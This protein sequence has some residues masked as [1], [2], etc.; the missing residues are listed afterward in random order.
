MKP[1]NVLFK[2]VNSVS[3][4]WETVDVR[5]VPVK[6]GDFGLSRHVPRD[7]GTLTVEVG[8]DKYWAPEIKGGHYGPKVDVFSIGVIAFEMLTG[9]RPEEGEDGTYRL[10][11]FTFCKQC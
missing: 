6:V 9:R 3:L 5:T 11:R 10:L 7:D 2:V 4:D 1:S 8:T